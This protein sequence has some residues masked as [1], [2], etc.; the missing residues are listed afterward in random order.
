MNK[1]GFTVVVGKM[2]ECRH[3]TKEETKK[4]IYLQAICNNKT[5]QM[6]QVEVVMRLGEGDVLHFQNAMR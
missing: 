5:I 1:E 6:I 3:F 2:Y 4:I